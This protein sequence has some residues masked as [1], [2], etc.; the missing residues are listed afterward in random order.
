MFLSNIMFFVI[1]FIFKHDYLTQKGYIY[2][3]LPLFR[4]YDLLFY[5]IGYSAVLSENFEFLFYLT[6]DVYVISH[7]V[8]CLMRTNDSYDTRE[9]IRNVVF[10]PLSVSSVPGKSDVM[11]LQIPQGSLQ[12]HR[13]LIVDLK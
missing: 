4:S 5:Y 13:G 9:S 6:D 3:Y 8:G 2:F 12:L 1:I 10:D 7:R 11:Q